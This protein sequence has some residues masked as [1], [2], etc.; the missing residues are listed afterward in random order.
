M[1]SWGTVSQSDTPQLFSKVP[2]SLGLISNPPMMAPKTM[3][4]TVAPSIQL[5]AFTS[6]AGGRYSVRMP[7]L[8]GE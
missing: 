3:A 7:Y 4:A 8:A 6:W 5:L 2:I 1:A